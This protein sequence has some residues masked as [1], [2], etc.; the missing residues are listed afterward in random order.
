M[1][2]YRIRAI[3]DPQSLFWCHIHTHIR[4]G[5]FGHSFFF[6]EISKFWKKVPHSWLQNYFFQKKRTPMRSRVS[7]KLHLSV[8]KLCVLILR[9]RVLY[10]GFLWPHAGYTFRIRGT[11]KK[12][13]EPADFKGAPSRSVCVYNWK[14]IKIFFRGC[15]ELGFFSCSILALYRGSF[16]ESIGLDEASCAGLWS[17]PYFVTPPSRLPLFC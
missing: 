6:P 7:S 8:Q 2:S 13:S 17:R 5:V 14:I 15:H 10:T 1:Q 11:R 9:L 16:N 3:Y 12:K 4:A